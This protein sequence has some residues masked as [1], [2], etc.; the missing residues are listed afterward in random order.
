MNQEDFGKLLLCVRKV[1]L[2]VIEN[3]FG[4]NFGDKHK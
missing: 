1:L 3:I 4:S 2:G